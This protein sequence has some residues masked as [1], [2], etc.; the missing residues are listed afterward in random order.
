[1]PNFEETILIQAQTFNWG[2]LLRSKP[3]FLNMWNLY[4]DFID[5]FLILN[6]LGL[7]ETT[8]NRIF[9]GDTSQYEYYTTEETY[10]IN[11]DTGEATNHMLRQ[12]RTRRERV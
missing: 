5:V 1:M 7:C 4:L 12:R 11:D 3:S 8:Y 10:N 9:G 6:F 2:E